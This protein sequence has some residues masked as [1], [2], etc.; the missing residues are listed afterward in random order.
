[1]IEN[2]SWSPMAAR[3]MKKMLENSKEI[4]YAEPIVTLRSAQNGESEAQLAA[5]AG[6]LSK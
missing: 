4:V 6:A 1:M 3:T 5:L 2:G